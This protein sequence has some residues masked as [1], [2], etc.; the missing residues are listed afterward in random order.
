M[1]LAAKLVH[2]EA[3]ASLPKVSVRELWEPAKIT[4][5]RRVRTRYNTTCIML[6]IVLKDGEQRVTF[7]PARFDTV[8][9]DQE[10]GHI[11]ETKDYSVKCT[12]TVGNSPSV[13]IFK[14]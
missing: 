14:H 9:T 1:D 6:E 12:A 7:L 11:S 13:L 10:L 8:L 5:A 2:F 3:P 4:Y